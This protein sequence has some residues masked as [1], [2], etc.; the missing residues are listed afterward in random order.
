LAH[1]D[2]ESLMFSPSILSGES[3]GWNVHLLVMSFGDFEGNGQLRLK[4]MNRACEV[5][6]VSNCTTLDLPDVR[7]GPKE[8][9]S[10]QRIREIVQH[11]CSDSQIQLVVTF[12]DHGVTGHANHAALYKALTQEPFDWAL[13]P[14]YRLESVNMIRHYIGPLDTPIAMVNLLWS[15]F[16]N[17][18]EAALLIND[19]LKYRLANQAFDCHSTQK[20]WFRHLNTIMSKFM[21]SNTLEPVTFITPKA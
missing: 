19:W 13:P 8:V 18:E 15:K 12:D 11:Y 3:L 17:K 14:I 21:Y 9:W 16:W 5:L 20:V 7:D 6:V 1:P 10:T 2:D 4:E